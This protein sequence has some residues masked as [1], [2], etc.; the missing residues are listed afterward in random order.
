M[1]EC[2]YTYKRKKYTSKELINLLASDN[3]IVDKYRP[4]EERGDYQKEDMDTFIKK[5]DHLKKSMNVEVIIDSDV[6]TSRVLSSTDPRT[7]HA[8][9]PVILINP[10]RVF[11]T[12]A[13]H[14]FAHIF[15]DAFPSGLKNKRLQGAL[16]E[17][18]GTKLYAEVKEM[19][20]ELSEEMFS[21]ELLATAIGR[22]GSEIWDNEQSAS[23]WAGFVNWFFDYLRRTFGLE[24][25]KVEGLTRE[26][27]S[28]KVKTGLMEN[29]SN[30][31]Q[32]E[33]FTTDL[34]KEEKNINVSYNEIVSSISNLHSIHKPKSYKDRKAEYEALVKG[35]STSFSRIEKL[36]QTLEEFNKVDHQK[37]LF[38]YARWTNQGLDSLDRMIKKSKED[39]KLNVDLIR[40]YKDFNASFELINDVER[41][42]ISEAE[43][44]NLSEMRKEIL[45]KGVSDIKRKNDLISNELLVAQRYAYANIMADNSNEHLVEWRQ[46]Y[47]AQYDKIEPQAEKMAWVNEK[48]ATNADTIRESAYKEYL[49]RAEKSFSDINTLGAMFIT[50]KNL[51]SEEIQV[52]SKMIDA[53]DFEIAKYMLSRA[54]EFK[55]HHN[56][57]SKRNPSGN[58]SEK[59]KKFIDQNE[60]SSYL[61]GEY[62]SSF[63]EAYDEA[64]RKHNNPDI[65]NEAY[66]DIVSKGDSYTIDGVTKKFQIQGK[67]LKAEGEFLSYELH[68]ASRKMEIK[69]AIALSEYRAWKDENLK[70]KKVGISK[71]TVPTDKWINEEYS[72]L[73]KEDK[74]DLKYFREKI[75]EADNLYD[76]TNSLISTGASQEFMKLPGVTKTTLAR[77]MDGK[78]KSAVIDK[79]TDMFKKK[80]DE[81]ELG[82]VDPDK[83][84][85]VRVFADVTNKEKLNVQVPYRGKLSKDDQSVDL[86]TILLMNLEGAKNFKEKKKLENSLH[87]MADVMTNRLVPRYDGLSNVA[88]LHGFNKKEDIQLHKPK[89]ELPN[90]VKKLLDMMENRIYGIKSKDA[91]EVGGA[92]VQK[93]TSTVLKYSGSVSLI[94]N[95]LNSI[96]NAT[97]GTVNNLIEAIGGE[98]YTLSDWKEGKFK[99]WKDIQGIVTDIGSNVQTSRT[100]MFLNIFNVLGSK[101][102]FNNNFEENTRVK[103][104]FKVHSLRPLAQGGE[105]MMQSQVMYAIMNSIKVLDTQGRYLDA[106]GKVVSSKKDAASLDDVMIFEKGANGTVEMKLPSFVKATTFTQTGGHANI[107]LETRN[108]IK[109]KIIDLHGNYDS[110]LQA[111]AQRE[112]W[113]KLVFFLRKWIE[114]TT[115]RRWRGLP[116]MLKNSEDLRRVDKFYSQDLKSFQEGYYVTAIRFIK[117][118]VLKGMKEFSFN[119]I[120]AD[121]KNLSVHEQANLKKIVAEFSMMGLTVLAYMAMGGFDEEPDEDTLTARYLLR[122]ELSELSFYAN[123]LEAFKIASS[124]TAAINTTQRVFKFISQAL[125][126][127]GSV[128]FGEGPERY[129]QGDKVG[130]MKLFHRGVS[131]LPGAAQYNKDL[132]G[133][134][135]FLQVGD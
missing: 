43:K 66:K 127:T 63:I 8:G 96:V 19:Y 65:Y 90:D 12:T 100:N 86:H 68:G 58:S 3:T 89:D 27:L 29:L 24:R 133:A 32:E 30:Q 53:S 67:N 110:D 76:G 38:A 77:L 132:E 114:S 108:L 83:G 107:L 92:N 135:R 41:I 121:Y 62:K 21:K 124:P 85:G 79:V 36:K 99:Y 118:S 55:S 81:F 69:K 115:L 48:M 49:D 16:K 57:F 122:R 101:E 4:Q 31:V 54:N 23:K 128:I 134:M 106:N 22:K 61:I 112:W 95:Y 33:R 80:S 84:L 119:A 14:E 50:E 126:D 11:K 51:S 75:R 116:H 45:L 20:P 6:K 82:E 104:L 17:L 25:S 88:K 40:K 52:A 94:G 10:E 1:A 9:K 26:L 105:H 93:A 56:D 37:G 34:E 78:V 7:V 87:A 64:K 47:E 120:G 39:G 2:T 59:Y 35:K 72:K 13:I 131:I 18:E 123:P 15:V 70:V 125:S 130:E 109:K 46:K 98:T 111:A 91:G 5:I 74:K 102:A 129:K 44:G 97:T 42:I 103:T 28:D 117:H 113:G 73:S 60:E 71:K